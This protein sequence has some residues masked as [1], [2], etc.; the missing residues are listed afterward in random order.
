[1][2]AHIEVNQNERAEDNRNA[3]DEEDSLAFGEF[4]RTRDKGQGTR[5]KGQG[6]RDKG[7]CYI[8]HFSTM[9]ILRMKYDPLTLFQKIR[10]SFENSAD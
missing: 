8:F 1:V 9:R 10:R 6:T 4:H 7:H 5:D 3:A 2:R